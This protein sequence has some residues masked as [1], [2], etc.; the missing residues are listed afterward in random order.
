MK[1]RLL[2][3]AGACSLACPAFA[4][5][6]LPEVTVRADIDFAKD[7]AASTGIVS[8]E[9]WETRPLL[10]P[11]E[12]MEAVPGMIA[13][14]HSGDGKANQYYLRG[15]NLDHGTDFAVNLMGM[16]LNMP[17]HAHGQGY[18][19]VNFLIPELVEAMEYRKGPYWAEAG[20]FS[21]AGAARV[22]YRQSLDRSYAQ[23]TAGQGNYRRG[24]LA[25]SRSDADGNMLTAV[26]AVGNDG[27]WQTPEALRKLNAVARYGWG[28]EV[29]GGSVALMAYDGHWNATDQVARRAI[30][31]GLVDR[32]GSLDSTDG[33]KAR[34]ISL[35]GE[36]TGSGGNTRWHAN[37]Y[38]IDS[39]LDLWS[40]F[41]YATDPVHGDQFQQ[42]DQRRIYG[43][44]ASQNWQLDWRVPAR[45]T[46][47]G[48]LR[49]D[50]I[51]KLGLY[52]TDARRI[53]ATVR[54]DAVN[55]DASGLYAKLQVQWSTQWRSEFGLRGD[56]QRYR[57]DS[58]RGANSGT[59]GGHLWSP[60]FSLA[61][62]PARQAEFFFNA[63]LGFHSNDGRGTTTRVNPDPRDSGYLSTVAPVTAM[64]RT[65]GIELGTRLIPSSPMRISASLWRLD[66]A[67]EL[68][69]TGDA[70]T[71]EPSRPSRRQGIELSAEWR[72]TSGITANA[73]LALSR[74]RFTT[75]DAAGN[76]I[77][78]A[79]GRVASIGIDYVP[80]A[81]W[82]LGAT[83]RHFGPRPLVE[84]NSIRSA[85]STLINLR[86][87]YGGS[88]D[89]MLAVDVLNLFGSKVSDV[90]YFYASQLRGESAPVNDV[91]THP[92]EPRTI[93]LSLR[94]FL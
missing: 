13:S 40:N 3:L 19:D 30:D 2:A 94:W 52:L 93:R 76:H 82:T 66:Q 5:T 9:R 18:L 75:E 24:L 81:P 67:S 88:R 23:V 84:D 64:V 86:S 41:S 62:A 6:V 28:S 49:M 31:A 46:L 34:R 14:Q 33:G 48:Q 53:W 54:E 25:G 79:V 74:A 87:T 26:E 89:L 55:Q 45:L 91:H 50:R 17:T 10:R 16:P 35:S 4:D 38:A 8:G 68:L 83:L 85:A 15:F 29:Q 51:G 21:S 92:A 43:G 90:D 7:A 78:G 60:K 36:W 27:P 44:S 59:A 69:F 12:V 47:G 56:W 71:T 22:D 61:F 57:V 1:R 32:Y 37:A 39:T 70:G 58:D 20:D 72:L 63:G 42:T 77:P 73:D 65:R 11:G 80:G